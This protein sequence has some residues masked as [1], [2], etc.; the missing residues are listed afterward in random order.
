MGVPQA[1]LFDEIME[2]F[3]FSVGY[4]SS[5]QIHAVSK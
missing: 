3:K 4:E 2:N 1:D 5:K